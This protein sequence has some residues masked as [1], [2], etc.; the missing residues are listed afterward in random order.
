M[1][2]CFYSCE[3]LYCASWYSIHHVT[4]NFIAEIIYI[5]KKTYYKSCDVAIDILG[6]TNIILRLI[7]KW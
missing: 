5:K 4:S 7:N 2:Q 6:K 1:Y 3:Y